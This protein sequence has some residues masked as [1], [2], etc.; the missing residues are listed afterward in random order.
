M[1]EDLLQHLKLGISWLSLDQ[2]NVD[3]IFHLGA[4][5]FIIDSGIMQGHPLLGFILGDAQVFP[6]NLRQR[7]TGGAEDGD[8]VSGGHGTAVA[9]IAA[10]GDLGDCIN[11]RVF[12]PKFD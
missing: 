5:N 1:I 12:N 4:G 2:V 7:I 3:L 6:D 9:G 11:R 10:Y 8:L